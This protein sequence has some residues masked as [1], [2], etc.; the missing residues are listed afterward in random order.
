MLE[1]PDAHELA[2]SH[3]KTV[4]HPQEPRYEQLGLLGFKKKKSQKKV[5]SKTNVELWV[6][7]WQTLTAFLTW[8]GPCVHGKGHPQR[9]AG[10]LDLPNVPFG[11]A[12]HTMQNNMKQSWHMGCRDAVALPFFFGYEFGFGTGRAMDT[13]V[14]GACH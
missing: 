11:A 12:K 3:R 1:F 6:C 8:N 5:L 13:N 10:W 7:P 4:C 2:L 14:A 9:L